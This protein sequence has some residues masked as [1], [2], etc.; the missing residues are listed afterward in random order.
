MPSN[1]TR[2]TQNALKHNAR[3]ALQIGLRCNLIGLRCNLG[4]TL[5]NGRPTAHFTRS[6]FRC[7]SCLRKTPEYFC[8]VSCSIGPGTSM[9]IHV[10]QVR[11]PVSSAW[12]TNSRSAMFTSVLSAQ[13]KGP[14]INRRPEPRARPSC[15]GRYP[16][17][18]PVDVIAKKECGSSYETARNDTQFSTARHLER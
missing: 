6:R 16:S 15:R 9:K 10:S 4:K 11:A 14:K 8:Q 12:S 13:G 1:T 3:L 2:T 5:R 7:C 17:P 18:I